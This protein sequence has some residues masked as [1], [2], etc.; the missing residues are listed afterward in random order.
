MLKRMAVLG[1]LG[2]AGLASGCTSISSNYTGAMTIPDVS[3]LYVC[4]GFDCSYKT[5]LDVGA[6]DASRFAE[7]MAG[8]GGSAAAE[9]VAISKSVQYFE[10]R[11]A[12]QIGIRDKPKSDI[13]QSRERGQMDCIDE[14][15]NT[16]TLLRFLNERGL[17]KFHSVEMNVSRGL[18]VDGR[19]PH[20]T[21]VLRE[22]AGGQRWA[23]DSWYEPMGGPP[24]I[25]PLEAW[26]VRGVMGQR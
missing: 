11:A 23:V 1:M 25:M 7:I 17:L 6:P 4:H 24:D 21:A 13:S 12:Q 18:F 15:T 2:V 22:K 26:S 19:Y 10:D 20:S 16:R 14:S 3:R 5:K 8:G 9:R